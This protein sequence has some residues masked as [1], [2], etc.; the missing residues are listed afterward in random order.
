MPPDAPLDAAVL[1]SWQRCVA[2]G[3]RADE[4]VVFDPVAQAALARLLDRHRPLLAQARPELDRLAE[5]LA[6]TGGVVLL[7]DAAGRALATAG[8][9][10]T[11]SA[12]LRQA[13][14]PGVDLSEAAI[15]TSAM[16][17]ALQEA[18][19]VQVSG[20][21]H[22]F[23]DNQIFHCAAVPVRDPQGQLLAVLDISRDRPGL[24]ALAT[25]LLQQCAARI[26]ARL[27]EAV[28]GFLHLQLDAGGGTP[29]SLV[30]GPDGEVLAAS[31]VLREAG[32][33]PC[34]ALP[35]GT[36]VDAV[37]RQDLCSLA[38]RGG[39]RL[40]VLSA[41]LGRG[42][43]S[44]NSGTSAVRTPK[45]A[46]RPVFGDGATHQRFLQALRAHDAE[47]AVLI[48]G[49][50]GTG[51]EVAARALHAAGSRRDGP[52]VALNCGALAPELAAAEL[53]G[54]VEGAYTGARRGGSP[55]RFE[56]A[57][58]GTLLLDEI[59]DMPMSLQVALL[60]VLDSG[61]L[62]RVGSHR[63]LRPQVRIICA[64]HRDLR[65]AVR[66]GRFRE[67]LWHRI[68][69]FELRLPPLRERDDF[70]ALLDAVMGELGLAPQRLGAA[71]RAELRRRHWGGNLRELRQRLRVAQ[72]LADPDEPLD[73]GMAPAPTPAPAAVPSSAPLPP[74]VRPA[75]SRW[76][77]LQQ[78][79]IEQ[80]L[81]QCDGQVGAAA[82]LLGIGR[83]TLYRRLAA[84]R[85]V[86]TDSALTRPASA[87]G[88]PPGAD[89]SGNGA[90]PASARSRP[91]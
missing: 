63:L 43:A 71:R 78:E 13:F 55:G 15:G 49:E 11:C 28:P 37:R 33:A 3:R 46:G 5:T 19:P 7:T 18:R 66:A 14:R 58:G 32:Q 62:T 86:S 83:A 30:L 77:Q 60:R 76:H 75:G 9:L 35:F 65:E 1:R 8:A 91:G 64:T 53:F 12:P 79:A 10:H 72:A 44:T 70:D 73:D 40:T 41:R 74:P 17:A 4:S 82:A 20:A 50:T 84:A 85:P 87:D 80:A 42:S 36:L 48:G 47:L 90:P 22:F 81:R 25:A 67:D 56:A 34:P 24:P 68:S 23:E 69:G 6:G 29:A 2:Q 27:L 57:D 61:E 26:E 51:K 52:F 31:A 16:S 21:E 89:A 45:P 54:H 39:P 88:E 59:G 38:L